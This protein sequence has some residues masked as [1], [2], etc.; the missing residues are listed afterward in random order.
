MLCPTRAPTFSASHGDVYRVR[1]RDMNRALDNCDAIIVSH[2]C[3]LRAE[4]KLVD[5][6]TESEHADFDAA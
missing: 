3:G 1:A 2:G 6:I 4:V 5:C